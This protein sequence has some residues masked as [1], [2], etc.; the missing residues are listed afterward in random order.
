MEHALRL[1]K[2]SPRRA[3]RLLSRLESEARG[4]L[5]RD[6]LLQE[7][8]S[9]RRRASRGLVQS[10]FRVGRHLPRV[11][12]SRFYPEGQPSVPD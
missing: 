7:E 3:Q 8:R 4:L 10:L 5:L 2:P 9:R 11:T 6:G 12:G 1:L